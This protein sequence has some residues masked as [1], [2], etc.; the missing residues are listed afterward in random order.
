[1]AK[2][3]NKVVVD[4][5]VKLDLSKDSVTANT[6]AKGATGHDKRGAPIVGTMTTPQISVAGSVMTIA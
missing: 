2:N 4:G 6:L 3:V 1:M 5:A